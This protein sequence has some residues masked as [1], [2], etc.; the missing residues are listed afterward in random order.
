MEK[1]IVRPNCLYICPV[2]PERKRRGE[3]LP[4]AQLTW[5]PLPQTTR[6]FPQR[7]PG[8]G[9]ILFLDHASDLLDDD[10][11]VIDYQTSCQDDAK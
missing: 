10:N 4:S 1:A 3:T 6:A 7:Q 5:Q 11:R 9:G 8:G 2:A